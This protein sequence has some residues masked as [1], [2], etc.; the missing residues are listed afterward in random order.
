M[1]F[2]YDIRSLSPTAFLRSLRPRE[3]AGGL[4]SPLANVVLKGPQLSHEGATS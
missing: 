2:A 4:K 3:A 1:L